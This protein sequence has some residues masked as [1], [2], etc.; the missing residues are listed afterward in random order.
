MSVEIEINGKKNNTNIN[1]KNKESISNENLLESIKSKYITQNIFS[2][3][4]EK[5][6]LKAIKYNK[7]LQD[8]MDITLVNYKF[9]NGKYIIYEKNGKGKEYFISDDRLI[10][11]GNIYMGKE[12]EKEKNIIIMVNYYL[13]VS[14]RMVKEMEKGKNMIIMVTFNLK[15]NIKKE[16]NG[17][18]HIMI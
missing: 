18:E 15:V 11:E 2:Y 13:M 17:M 9:F 3:F 14:I 1:T 4:N 10:F 6:K 12:M 16:I 7:K 8:I 5:I